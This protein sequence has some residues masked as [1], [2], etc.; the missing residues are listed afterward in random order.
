MPDPIKEEVVEI[1]EADTEIPDS[2]TDG[3]M[4]EGEEEDAEPKKKEGKKESEAKPRI[5]AEDR[6]KIED[7]VKES[8]ARKMGFIPKSEAKGD[9]TG[10][11]DDPE[12]FIVRQRDFV[13]DVARSNRELKEEL[14]ELR[15]QTSQ[16]GKAVT[17][18]RTQEVERDYGSRIEALKAQRRAATQE[19]DDAAMER[20][21][22]Q[23]DSLRNE[24]YVKK[25]SVP[26]SQA[27]EDD[28]AKKARIEAER[29]ESFRS[30]VKGNPWFY[31]NHELALMAQ[32]V[33]GEYDRDL[34]EG[35]ITPDDVFRKV[36]ERMQ[37]YIPK[38]GGEPETN[39]TPSVAGNEPAK[40]PVRRSSANMVESGNPTR[41]P[42]KTRVEYK[43]NKPMR[44]FIDQ[45]KQ[46]KVFEDDKDALQLLHKSVTEPDEDDLVTIR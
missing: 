3:F 23:I 19:G 25:A 2:E 44:A 17:E 27:P 43:L 32:S 29:G 38:S 33:C 24:M 9:T 12:E 37:P 39:R 21:S 42:E 26:R 34:W 20:I 4:E 11:I 28:N 10:F 22:D 6:K 5:S 16:I 35:R 31:E 40:P 18:T 30:W 14:R 13:K 45:M 41:T 8:L 36:T 7:E 46:A 15:H 1:V